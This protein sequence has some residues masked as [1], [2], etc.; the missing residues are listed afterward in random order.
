MIVR[1]FGRSLGEL[2][3]LNCVIGEPGYPVTSDF[4]VDLAVA[5]WARSYSD[6]VIEAQA[7]A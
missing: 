6:P 4:V 2:H 7:I 5:G 1:H 3:D